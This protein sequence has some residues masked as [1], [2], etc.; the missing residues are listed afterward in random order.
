M[1]FS[2]GR[3]RLYATVLG[4]APRLPQ[5]LQYDISNLGSGGGMAGKQ[6]IP[7]TPTT[8]PVNLGSMQA[9]PDGKI[10][11]AREGQTALG[12]IPY[13]DSLGAAIAYAEDSLLLNG[14]RSGLGLVNFN[15][16]SLLRFGFG[17]RPTGCLEF[18][19]TAPPVD[20]DNKQYAWD[21][22]DGTTSTQADSVKHTYPRPGDYV[23]TLRITTDCFCRETKSMV[24]IFGPPTPGTLA[25]DQTICAGDS[26]AVL[27]SP[28]PAGEGTGQF[29]YQWQ[30]SADNTTWTDIGGATA[31]TYAPGVLNVNTFFR[32]LVTSGFCA[33]RTPSASV[34]ITVTPKVVA[35]TIAADQAL[36]AGA[37][38]APLTSAT[39]P[40]GGT[41]TFTYQWESSVDN[42]TFTAIGG[43]TSAGYAPGPLTATTYYRLRTTSGSCA[44]VLTNVVTITVT[45]A[46][47]AGSIAANQAICAGN[48]PAPLT[49]TAPATG[50]TGT[51]AYQWESSVDNATWA[52]IAG[53]TGAAY[54]P[55]VLSVTTYFRRQVSSGACASAPSNVVTITVT[56]ALTAG[57]IA[58]DQAVCA[59]SPVAPLTNT[60]APTGGTGTFAYQWESSVNNTTWTAIAGATGPEYAPGPLT[61]TTYFRRQVSSGP[62]TGLPSNVVTITVTPA[63]TAGTIAANQT[64]CAGT[65][66]ALLTSTVAAAGGNGT[67]VYQWEASVDNTTWTAVTGATGPTY[68]PGPLTATT[69]FRRRATSGPC[70]PVV[71][72]VVTITVTPALAAGTIAADQTLC[73]GATPAPLTSATAPTGGTGTFTYQWE[74][75][76]D[77][78]NWTAVTG[79]TGPTYAPGPLTA[80]TYFRRQVSS[81]PCA[82]LP[83]NVVTITVLPTLTA[84]TIAADQD[85]CAGTAPAPLTSTG[86]AGGGTGTFAYQWESSADNTTW[87][88]IGGATGKPTPPARS[89]LPPTSVAVSPRVP[90]PARPEFPT[91]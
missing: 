4:A 91:S 32:R 73:A 48:P 43:A 15:Q 86:A 80:T 78:T 79:A 26:A 65:A 84:G 57:T 77:N 45:P 66:P 38:P 64:V 85:I 17:G 87:T 33:P 51:F 37:T 67:I 16:S 13:P 12:F 90:A 10:Y 61:V 63:L 49:S 70:G 36:C 30:S 62:C 89:R 25:A 7:L 69:S 24:R 68:A 1:E 14:R 83:S 47:V 52:P 46:V 28:T 39:A 18:T 88:A 23:V 60:A 40:T 59:G 3:S 76:V 58:A 31:E 2:P 20:F 8:P 81:G 11:V 34:K 56:P 35:G 53:A 74:A 41:G 22:G 21:F 75:S 29:S 72:N 44:P 82:N 5:L 54:T 71:S 9:A 27:T 42:T 50:G 19:F 55:G 6:S